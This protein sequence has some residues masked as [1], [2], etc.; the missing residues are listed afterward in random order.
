[1]QRIA[2]ATLR[3]PGDG[4]VPFLIRR[5]LRDC[6]SLQKGEAQAQTLQE[7]IGSFVDGHEFTVSDIRDAYDKFKIEFV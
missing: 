7:N 3:F 5:L 2:D 4:N 6:N 1:M